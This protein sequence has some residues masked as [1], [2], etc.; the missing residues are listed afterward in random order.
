MI[1]DAPIFDSKAMKPCCLAISANP[2][3]GLGDASNM[4]TRPFRLLSLEDQSEFFAGDL[5]INC[6]D[7]LAVVRDKAAHT[8]RQHGFDPHRYIMEK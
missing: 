7:P 4:T 6:D 2:A 8:A 5:E 3:L 1:Q